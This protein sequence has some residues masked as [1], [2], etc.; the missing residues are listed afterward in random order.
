[1]TQ[2]F[3]GDCNRAR[4]ST[5]GRL[6]TC[7]FAGQGFDLRHLLRGTTMADDEQLARA[8]AS[9]WRERSDRYSQRRARWA[10]APNMTAMPKPEMSYIGG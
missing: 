2:A 1:M 6:F 8:I 5:E 10:E 3:C 4:L 7:L 9:V